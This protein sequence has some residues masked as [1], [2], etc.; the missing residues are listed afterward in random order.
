MMKLTDKNFKE[1]IVSMLKYIKESV[2]NE[3]KYR[4]S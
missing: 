2:Y 1:V 4:K 3:G